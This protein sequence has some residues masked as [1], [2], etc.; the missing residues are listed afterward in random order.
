MTS[1]S[2]GLAVPMRKDKCGF[3]EVLLKRNIHSLN[4]SEKY[5]FQTLQLN[6]HVWIQAFLFDSGEMPG[7]PEGFAGLQLGSTWGFWEIGVFAVQRS[8]S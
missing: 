3:S 7:G 4:K 8:T 1:I 5:I 6:P 2:P